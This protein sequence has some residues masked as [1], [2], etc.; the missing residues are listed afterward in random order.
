LVRDE[1][2]E[3]AI[4]PHRA[5]IVGNKNTVVELQHSPICPEDIEARETYYGNMV[6]LFDATTRFTSVDLGGRSFFSLG[7]TKHLE[8][9]TKPVF[10][11][12]GFSVVQV[13]KFTD[14]ITM[15]SGYGSDRSREWF[16]DNY[17]SDVREARTGGEF[18]PDPCGSDPWARKSPVRKLK[19]ETRWFDADG[20]KIVTYPKWTE[21]IRLNY[22]H[23]KVGDSQNKWYDYDL[24]IDRHAD[25]ANG[26]TKNELRQMKEVF[27]GTPIILG[28]LLRLLPAPIVSISAK[29]SVSSTKRLLKFADEHIRAGRLPVLKDS[30]KADL[31]RKAEERELQLYGRLLRP[32]EEK[33]IKGIFKQGSLFE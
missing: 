11:D 10:F 17:L 2:V 24:V 4:G 21:Y 15:V 27:C 18:I 8:L 20:G 28:G 5:D 7:K 6:W 25:L 16:V 1:F 29:N 26:W 12:F 3:V 9:C 13:R 23:W 31:V 33:V 22:E 14:A 30:T 19:H 32:E